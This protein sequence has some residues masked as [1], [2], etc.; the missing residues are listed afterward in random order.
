MFSIGLATIGICLSLQYTASEQFGL[1]AVSTNQFGFHCLPVEYAASVGLYTHLLR[2]H[3]LQILHDYMELAKSVH[4]YNTTE[5]T[6]FGSPSLAHL[7]DYFWPFTFPFCVWWVH[8]DRIGWRFCVRTASSSP[9]LTHACHFPDRR[10]CI[11]R[12]LGR[13]SVF[14]KWPVSFHFASTKK[15]SGLS[16][17]HRPMT[18][19]DHYDGSLM[20]CRIRRSIVCHVHDCQQQRGYT[21]DR[22]QYNAIGDLGC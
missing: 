4:N 18:A 11:C 16:H 17:A 1:E 19:H 21:V 22:F 6:V 12:L 20:P 3:L 7:R 9:L 14:G 5:W 10:W 8:I 13:R 15:S 2:R